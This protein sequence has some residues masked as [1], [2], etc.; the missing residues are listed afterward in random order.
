[1]ECSNNGSRGDGT[2]QGTCDNDFVCHAN[3]ACKLEGL[4]IFNHSLIK[5]CKVRRKIS[6]WNVF[7]QSI[8]NQI[9]RTCNQIEQSKITTAELLKT[10]MLKAGHNCTS[11]SEHRAYPG[12]PY[13]NTRNGVCTYLTKGA[14]S[15]C[16]SNSYAHHRPLC[17]WSGNYLQLDNFFYTNRFNF[18]HNDWL[19]TLN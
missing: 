12:T 5:F 8:C 19:P 2:T 10:A 14:T 16:D 13:T 7:F 17:Y 18:C 9:G 11:I 15:V 6:T 3:G 4:K 1:M